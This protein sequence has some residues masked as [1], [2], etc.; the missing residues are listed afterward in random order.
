MNATER[1]MAE[2]PYTAQQYQEA[3]RAFLNDPIRKD[4]I[5]NMGLLTVFQATTFTMKNNEIINTEK[6]WTNE[7]A[8]EL[9]IKYETILKEYSEN[10]WEILMNE[11]RGRPVQEND[12]QENSQTT[13]N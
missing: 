10:L 6:R 13:E 2:K 4:I 5:R 9:Y 12:K 3:K 7:Q 8:K 1:A 11:F